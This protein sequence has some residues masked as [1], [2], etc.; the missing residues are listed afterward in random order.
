[1]PSHAISWLE[2]PQLSPRVSNGW[3]DGRL[4]TLKLPYTAHNIQCYCR[5]TGQL[6]MK[7]RWSLTRQQVRQLRESN[8]QLLNAAKEDSVSFEAAMKEAEQVSCFS[9]RY[10]WCSLHLLGSLLILEVQTSPS[11]S[12]HILCPCDGH[13]SLHPAARAASASRV[14]CHSRHSSRL[15]INLP[16]WDSAAGAMRWVTREVEILQTSEQMCPATD[17]HASRGRNGICQ[18]ENG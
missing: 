12:P 18:A 3:R 17:H 5:G 8:Y 1:M 4:C 15:S 16:P 10:P 13:T 11:L 2:C 7:R 14:L 9:S 6:Q